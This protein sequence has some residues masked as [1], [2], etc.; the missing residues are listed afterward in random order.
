MSDEI[1]E[2]TYPIVRTSTIDN[3]WEENA[4]QLA[5]LEGS[6]PT[7]AEK[8]SL[9]E[10]TNWTNQQEADIRTI[11]NELLEYLEKKGCPVWDFLKS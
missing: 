2:Y 6:N 11:Q 10:L 8:E 5:K 4:K 3:I 9:E 1:Q 7:E